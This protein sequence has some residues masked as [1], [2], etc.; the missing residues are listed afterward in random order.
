MALARGVR[1]PF[2]SGR[3]YEGLMRCVRCAL[4]LPHCPTYREL[5]VETASPRGRLALMKS[6]ADGIVAPDGHFHRH[7]HLCTDCRACEAAC[8]SGVP[9]GRL[10]ERSREMIE[11]TR[12]K[13]LLGRLA[14]FLGFRILL[15]RLPLI[16]LLLLPLRLL[17][18]LRLRRPL[19]RTRLLDRLSPRLGDLERMLPDLPL[20]APGPSL[21]ALI[22]PVGPMRARVALFTGCVMRTLFASVNRDTAEV[23]RQNGCEVIV[24]R[25]QGCC[26]AL[27]LHEGRR[28]E[29]KRLAL[30]NLRDFPGLEVDAV[31]A[32]A[33]GCG[34]VLKEYGLLFR[35]DPAVAEE[36]AAFSAKQKDVMEFLDGIGLVAPPNPVRLRIYYDAPCHLVHA[37]RV[38]RAPVRL[39]SQLPGAEI[40]EGP[41]AD[42]CCGS[43][44]IYNLT[45]PELSREMLDR[46]M[47]T[48]IPLDPDVIASG[49]PGCLM[50]IRAGAARW[51]LRAEVQ[52]PV[53]LLAMGYRRAP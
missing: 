11:K 44:G 51:G 24:P 5:R 33:A 36:A 1:E 26:G 53:E 52:H 16:D 6:V 12:R 21:P 42:W 18:A 32:N 22:P 2:L 41:D 15:P 28:S 23:L 30:R 47:K 43:A 25:E 20:K 48:I 17:H 46:K 13:S 31:I 35:E 19:Q 38:D 14:R 29:G 4:C 50:Q 49:N 34:A 8:P 39:L 7:M 40:V 45:H 10:M 27:H 3:D 37:Q 9:F